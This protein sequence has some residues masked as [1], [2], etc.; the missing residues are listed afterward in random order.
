MK[1]CVFVPVYEDVVQDADVFVGPNA[2][3]EAEEAFLNH[4]GVTYKAFEDAEDTDELL[5]PS[6]TMGSYIKMV[7]VP[8]K[9]KVEVWRGMAEETENPYGIEVE[10]DDKD[11]HDDEEAL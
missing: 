9:V 10:I 3:Q 7:D 6:D 4:T 5:R 8:V 1:I 2:E 11:T